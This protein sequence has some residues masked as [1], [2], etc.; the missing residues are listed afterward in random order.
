MPVQTVLAVGAHPDD[1]EL[2]CGGTLARYRRAGAR[3]HIASFTTGDKGSRD[4]SA[5]ETVRVR[6]RE[7]EAAAARLEATYTCLEQSDSELFETPQ[8]RRR[9]IE[10]LRAVQP[11]VVLTH[12]PNDYHADHQAAA[13]LVCHAAY[14]AGSFKYATESPPLKAVPALYYMDTLLGVDFLPEEYVDITDVIEVKK[15][16]LEEHAS[17]VAH[18]K[19]RGGDDI[20]EDMLILARLRGRQCGAAYGEGF[21]RF[22]AAGSLGAERLLP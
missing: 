19:A 9:T 15:A 18:L 16:L 6:R 7:A 10:L 1:V 17:Q 21:R 4:L 20:L 8:T 2:S 5:A 14:S 3:V 11:D 13:Q 12:A 22:R